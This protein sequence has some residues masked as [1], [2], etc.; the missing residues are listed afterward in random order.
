MDYIVARELN[1][2]YILLDCMFL[3]LIGYLLV[4]LKNYMALGFGVAGAMIYFIVDY[5]IF[6]LL[7]NTRVVTGADPM[8]F[9]LWLSASY[10]FTNFL[11]IWL[12]LDRDKK[13]VEWSLLIVIGWFS[14]AIIAQAFGSPFST[15][16][17]QR[18]TGSYHGFMAIM[19]LAG[20]LF[21]IARNLMLDHESPI[22][23]LRLLF[24]GIIVQFSWEAV[25]LISGIRP[26]G[27]RPLILNSLLETNLGIPYLYFI[28]KALKKYAPAQVFEPTIENPLTS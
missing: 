22:P 18:G 3:V 5:G 2:L 1:V 4:R 13:I 15:I 9:L 17:I 23:I 7:L 8:L 16:Q 11:W 19:L 12:F 21:V 24:I 26:Q 10:G 25:L 20:Y 14:I 6:Y 27:F 28:H